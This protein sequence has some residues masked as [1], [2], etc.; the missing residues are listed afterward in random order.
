MDSGYVDK[1]W[2]LPDVR[3]RPDPPRR[4]LRLR[5]E[6]GRGQDPSV[7]AGPRV[8]QGGV[9]GDSGDGAGRVLGGEVDT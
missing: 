1:V 6:G 8:R 7:P 9:V 2:V 4:H 5:D 3:P